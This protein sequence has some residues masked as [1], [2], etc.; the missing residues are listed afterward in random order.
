M[1]FPIEVGSR[2]ATDSL[3]GDKRYE[4]LVFRMTARF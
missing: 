4:A 3:I 2:H 1:S